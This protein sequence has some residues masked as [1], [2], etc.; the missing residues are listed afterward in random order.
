MILIMMESNF[1]CE[2][3]ISLRSH[4]MIKGKKI[5]FVTTFTKTWS[6][7][8]LFFFISA[9]CS[10]RHGHKKRNLIF[11]AILLWLRYDHGKNILFIFHWD[12]HYGNIFLHDLTSTYY[13]HYVTN[14]SKKF[15]NII[16]PGK[17]MCNWKN[18][19]SQKFH[20]LH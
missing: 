6:I 16:L 13:A 10:I 2:K 14:L 9:L 19:L 4:I 5:N 17:N 8:K 20:C 3:K 11:I 7:Q 12:V 18:C 1:L 15:P